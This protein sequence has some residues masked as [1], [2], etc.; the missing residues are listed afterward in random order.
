MSWGTSLST[1]S[2]CIT[3]SSS[4]LGGGCVTIFTPC[5]CGGSCGLARL[6][7]ALHWGSLS[8]LVTSGS[9]SHVLSVLHGLPLSSTSAGRISGSDVV[10]LSGRG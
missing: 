3:G 10:A 7:S 6:V 8:S 5:G 2:G 9:V 4:F 1:L